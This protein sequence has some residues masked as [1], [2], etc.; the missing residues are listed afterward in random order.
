M[1]SPASFMISSDHLNATVL[2]LGATLSAV[3]FGADGPNLVLGFPDV[4]DHAHIPAYSGALVGP[5][6]NR[7][8]D[9]VA[10]IQGK[11]HQ[12][13]ANEASGACLHSGP[14]GLH[15]LVWT[16]QKRTPSSIVLEIDLADGAQGLPGNRWLSAQYSIHD[17]TLRLDL[18]AT[19][20]RTTLMNVAPHPYWNLDQSRDIANHSL[21]IAAK[22]YLPVDDAN[23]PTGAVLET[24]GT[25]FDFSSPRS[26]P[27]EP[28]LD[29]NFCLADRPFDHPR[30]AATLTGVKGGRLNIETT[31][32]GL[33]VYNGHFLP[34]IDHMLENGRPLGPHAGIALEPQMWPDAP[35]HADFPSIL[36]HP[37]AIWQQ[38]TLYHLTPPK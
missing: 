31:A 26:I 15:A 11:T 24:S 17:T 12:L 28:W 14:N 23:L 10:S 38:T 7:I 27:L 19:T 13:A 5:V 36:L 30:R 25:T 2:P 37:G 21:W 18:Q 8:R 16:V 6:A 20:D 3:R 29:V 33:Q 35:H 34:Q 1:T 9:G 22:R 4:A 32:P